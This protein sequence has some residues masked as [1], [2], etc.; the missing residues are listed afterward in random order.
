MESLL[1]SHVIWS[2]FGVFDE[3]C[4][5]FLDKTWLSTK[6]VWSSWISLTNSITYFQ[7][8]FLI[9]SSPNNY[10]LKQFNNLWFNVIWKRG[11]KVSYLILNKISPRTPAEGIFSQTRLLFVDSVRT[12]LRSNSPR[13]FRLKARWGTRGER[14]DRRRTVRKRHLQ[15][16]CH[17]KS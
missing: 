4:Y 7:N 13:V 14:R 1:G 2:S 8:R 3:I 12:I 11:E 6:V 10:T 16:I 5:I 9:K 17:S 15:S